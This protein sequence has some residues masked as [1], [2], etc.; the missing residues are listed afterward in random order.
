MPGKPAVSP[1][2]VVAKGQPVSSFCHQL[3]S[4]FEYS[5]LAL[6]FLFSRTSMPLVNQNFVPDDKLSSRAQ[7]GVGMGWGRQSGP[8]GGFQRGWEMGLLPLDLLN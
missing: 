7:L 5:L 6:R 3:M 4:C 8:F 1:T 2:L